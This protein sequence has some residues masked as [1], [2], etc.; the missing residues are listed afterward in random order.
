MLNLSDFP[1]FLIQQVRYRLNGSGSWSHVNARYPYV[2]LG[3]L[4]SLIGM[5]EL[6]HLYLYHKDNSPI[7]KKDSSYRLNTFS[8]SFLTYS[9][10]LSVNYERLFALHHLGS[11]KGLISGLT[12]L[13]FSGTDPLQRPRKTYLSL[14]HHLTYVV[15]FDPLR[16]EVGLGGSLI[17]GQS[18]HY[19]GIAGLRLHSLNDNR[20]QLRAFVQA[21]VTSTNEEL[22]ITRIGWSIGLNF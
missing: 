5:H 7:T 13:G 10:V 9:S 6:N 11:V 22:F 15:G 2:S 8:L 18:A 19:F 12:G 14:P 4:T 3:K 1:P 16:I 20:I 21:P 17:N